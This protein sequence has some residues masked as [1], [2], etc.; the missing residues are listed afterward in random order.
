MSP[1][2]YI[3]GACVNTCATPR[4]RAT[5]TRRGASEVA[6]RR[7]K[8]ERPNSVLRMFPA[9][10]NP[11]A[12]TE[13]QEGV[14]S[15]RSKRSTSPSA[16]MHATVQQALGQSIE[17]PTNWHQA[18]CIFAL[19]SDTSTGDRMMQLGI[20]LLIVCVQSMATV[21]VVLSVGLPSCVTSS[22]CP[23]SQFC[24]LPLID[25]YVSGPLHTRLNGE[26]DDDSGKYLLFPEGFEGF[27]CEFCNSRD[28][29]SGTNSTW[30]CTEHKP[31]HEACKV[32]F[33]GEHPTHG[34]P[35]H[36]ESES[37]TNALR[38]M[39]RGDCAH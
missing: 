33:K 20:S 35:Y 4:A 26:G 17:Q 21:A 10:Q 29:M 30:L 38:A 6:G 23:D 7:T 39:H 32:C 28:G 8:T 36:T 12:A 11:V 16:D 15:V 14:A 3:Y 5:S 31:D 27:R 19:Y 24:K 2:V 9:I 22:Q 25:G 34:W 1:P 18:C 13:P 37:A